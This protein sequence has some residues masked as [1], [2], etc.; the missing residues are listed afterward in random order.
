MKQITLKSLILT[1]LVLLG[2]VIPAWGEEGLYKTAL[3]GE[4]YN[5]K[6]VSSYTDKWSATNEGFTVN[7]SYWNNYNNNWSFI[8]TG[9][10]NQAV[11]GT[12]T[13]A[14]AIDKPVSK[15]VLK[16]G[17]ITPSN[18]TSIKLYSGT[19]SSELTTL[20]GEFAKK[21]G[22][23]TVTISKP[24]E[25]RYYMIEAVCVKKTNGCLQVDSV[26]YYVQD[27]PQPG[28]IPTPTLSLAEGTY[29]KDQTL[30]IGVPEGASAVYYTTDG[31]DPKESTTAVDITES[32]TISITKTTTV[33][34]IALDAEAN[35]S[36]EVNRTYTFLPSIANT[37]ETAYTT[38]EAIALIDKTSSD[39]LAD[40]KV[41]VI[42][43]VSKV[44]SYDSTNNKSITYWLDNDAFQVYSGKGLNN[45]DFTGKDDLEFGAT[46][47]IYGNI[48]KYKDTY[49]FDKG[50]YLVSYTEPVP[51]TLES[52]SI[53]GEASK[54][55]YTEGD[56]F[57]VSG[58]V[59]TA[60]YSDGSTQNVTGNATWA[61]SPETLALD[62]KEVTVTATYEDMTVSKVVS[63]VVVKAPAKVDVDLTTNQTTTATEEKLEWS[64][65]L[66]TVTA[67][68]SGASTAANNYYGGAESRTSTRFYKNSTLTFSPA[69]LTD[70]DKIIYI[71][72]TENYA[73]VFAADGTWTNATVSRDGKTVVVIPI[74]GTKPVSAKMSGTTGGESFSIE[75]TFVDNAE[76]SLG[77]QGGEYCYATFSNANACKFSDAEIYTV[78]VEGD[79]LILEEVKSKQIPANTAVLVKSGNDMANITRLE[80]A[81]VVEATNMLQ[82]ASK[83]MSDIEGCVFFKLAYNDYKAKTGL[84][85]YYGAANGATFNVKSGT[86]YLAV[87]TTQASSVKGFVLDGMETGINGVEAEAGSNAAIYNLQGQRVQKAQH[88]LYI[89]NGK[90]YMVK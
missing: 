72:T 27:T 35:F 59:A 80:S 1:L 22:E 4:K 2:G 82:P 64:G 90:K 37:Q 40:E 87:P 60:T 31:S 12:I 21:A 19:S 25:N 41:Y 65:A 50:N 8:K 47:I 54:T 67:N 85:F 58:L 24:A 79:K 17:A 57:D 74:D 83:P 34:A 32:T 11:T 18:V 48:K 7:L 86:A 56:A 49:E 61:V 89:V 77:A 5:S 46:V 30:N 20:E 15:V 88:G 76:V 13:T 3:F 44:D 38:V 36:N 42:G 43:K 73:G 45:S 26:K 10:K 68:K 39:Q 23:Q 33:R 29:W 71:A 55:E 78:N 28:T 84:G 53:T 51:V 69:P 62:T 66:V 14:N 52:I 81:P 63:V 6:R 16:I 9:S 70:I 75:Y